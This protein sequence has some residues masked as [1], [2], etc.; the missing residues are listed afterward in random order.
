MLH[1]HRAFEIFSPCWPKTTYCGNLL[2]FLLHLK[3]ATEDLGRQE[4]RGKTGEINQIW[5]WHTARWRGQ[6]L[7]E[8]LRYPE[9]GI[10]WS[11]LHEL[12]D[13]HDWS[14]LGDHPLQVDD[15]GMLKLPHDAGLAQELPPLFLCVTWLQGLN[16]YC[17]FALPWVFQAPKAHLSKLSCQG[18]KKH[19]SS[20][21]TQQ[22]I[23]VRCTKAFYCGWLRALLGNRDMGTFRLRQSSW[24]RLETTSSGFK[25]GVLRLQRVF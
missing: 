19:T 8:T 11:I 20:K 9:E 24:W 18:G 14:A 21:E 6:W 15:I 2:S 17:V 13:N 25:W 12:C 4:W 16:S 22:W 7:W 10:Q 23:L 5:D 3:R 1:D